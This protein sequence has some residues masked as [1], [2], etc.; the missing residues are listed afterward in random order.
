M[1]VAWRAG[2]GGRTQAGGSGA[3]VHDQH[4]TP[5]VRRDIRSYA[6]EEHARDAALA[7]GAERDQACVAVVGDASDPLPGWRFRELE[8]LGAE[9][10]GLCQ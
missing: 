6:A 3:S 2:T 5:G 4:G 9:A 7:V 10:G 1:R 8:T